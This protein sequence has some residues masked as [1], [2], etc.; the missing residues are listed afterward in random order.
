MRTLYLVDGS[1]YIFRAFYAISP[2]TNSSGLPTNA[3][4]GF[5]R[6]LQKLLR[7]SEAKYIAVT[8]D[9]PEPTFRHAQYREYKAHRP[10]CPADLVPQLPYFRR[11][12][13]ALGVKCL[14]QPG[15]EADDIIATLTHRLKD[16]VDRVVI[17][18]G[19]KDLTQLVD[20]KVEV[21]DAMRDVRFTPAV[22]KEKFGVGPEQ[23]VDFLAIT[24]D[25]SDNIPGVKGIG[26]KTAEILLRTF[27][28]TEELLKQLDKVQE[29]KGL[30][31]ASGIAAKL[32]AGKA[33]LRL[34]R[35][36]VTLDSNVRPYSELAS[37]DELSW[38]AIQPNVAEALF[39]ELE[40]IK[41]LEGLK[42]NGARSVAVAGE[43]SCYAL[44]DERT[45]GEFIAELKTK[46]EFAFD[47]E[48]SSLDPLTCELIGISICAEAGKAY[49]L[50]VCA[51]AGLSTCLDPVKVRELL[52]PI[53]ADPRVRKVGSNLKFDMM[54]LE[55]KG[56]TLA[57]LS[58]DTMLASYV[59]N[60]D[61]R[62][63]GLK[64]LAATQLGITIPTF[65]ELVG[66]HASIDQVEIDKLRDYACRDADMSLRL[67]K[68]LGK[69]LGQPASERPSLRWVFEHIEMP[70]VPVLSHLELAGVGIDLGAL[71]ALEVE[72]SAE[73]ALAEREIYRLAGSE[74]NI[75][76]PKQ[77][78]EVLFE[79]LGIPTTGVKRTQTAYS[80]DHSVLAK[81][82][83]RH[84]IIAP[85]L[86]YREI[87]K[88]KSTYVDA[89]KRIV[90]PKTGRIHASFNQ[91]VAATGRLSSSEPN[92]QNI[93]IR[94]ARGRKIRRCFVPR[95]G[96]QF[97][98]ADYSQIELRVLAELSGDENLRAAF[99]K[100]EDIHAT[101][102]REL[103]GQLTLLDRDQRE[104]RRVAKTINFGVVYGM[105]ALRLAQE[106]RIPRKQAQEY[107][108]SYF[109]RYPRV[110]AFFNEQTAKSQETGYVETYFGRR[111]YLRDID[112][113]GR[114]QG[115]ATRSL[116]NAPIQGTAADIMKLAMI[117][118]H[119]ALQVGFPSS[120]RMVLQV[121]DELVIEAQ[122]NVVA[123]VKKVVEERMERAVDFSVPLC[124][125][126]RVG[127]SWE[128]GV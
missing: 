76:S 128:E 108:D 49:Y 38:T 124:V 25:S 70:L 83:T 106:L 102:A 78:N 127:R 60:P 110:K 66:P 37:V 44:V 100:G 105:G 42:T 92:L 67:E 58:F 33:E 72:F 103:F 98:C 4:Y 82:L 36:L 113:S 28:T 5:T 15:F 75:N 22:V 109:R 47:T 90:H 69:K 79:R 104:L 1:G 23:I 62:Q 73:L 126:S 31:G 80:T 89:L 53:L 101:T 45:L 34:S 68:T 107:I 52:G 95:A 97:I 39:T 35:E 29:M 7:D 51:S 93:P 63:H 48:T 9:T 121:H 119:R 118:L 81:L 99:Q 24:G 27:G 88:L 65:E 91:A 86:E 71:E 2:L 84:E 13:D 41:L 32:E 74:F 8:F 61:R 30:R 125:E 120:A 19:D 20:E 57:G 122:D 3:I 55:A 64:S 17:V 54:V 123:E 11:V 114:D 12:V 21:W 59:L 43:G 87:F 77:L 40:F 46:S 16:Q 56:Y 112:T 85:L 116:M 14:E 6:M 18:S 50:P 117:D 96:S 94:N 111:R 10:E 115:Y 26:P